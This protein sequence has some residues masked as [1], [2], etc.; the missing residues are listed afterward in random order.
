MTFAMQF[1]VPYAHDFY[2]ASTRARFAS[3]K[4]CFS[5]A[6]QH[7]FSILWSSTCTI[8]GTHFVCNWCVCVREIIILVN[9]PTQCAQCNSISIASIPLR[10]T[11][12]CISHLSPLY[13]LFRSWFFNAVSFCFHCIRPF[14]RSKS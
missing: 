4:R 1:R 7:F 14:L 6:T 8:N 11:I 3:L 9:M 5:F 13:V 2:C 12:Q 10:N